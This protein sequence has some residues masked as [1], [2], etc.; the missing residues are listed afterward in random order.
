MIRI[1]WDQ[2]VAILDRKRVMI[3]SKWTRNGPKLV[4]WG[5][6]VM[7]IAKS[8]NKNPILIWPH[9][10]GIRWTWYGP[11]QTR[12]GPKRTRCG[13]KGSRKGRKPYTDF[14]NALCSSESQ[15]CE[16]NLVIYLN[17]EFQL[18]IPNSSKVYFILY[19]KKF[20]HV[21]LPTQHKLRHLL[22]SPG[23]LL[24]LGGSAFLLGGYV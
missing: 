13:S 5:M 17:L 20:K 10:S 9:I 7:K 12:Y 4:K 8:I 15:N 11:K 14:L 1:F 21:P 2:K 18:S 23:V 3:G 6:Q 24:R 22:G 16:W 19:L